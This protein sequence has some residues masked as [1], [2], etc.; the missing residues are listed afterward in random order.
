MIT[1]LALRPC[2]LVLR[3]RCTGKFTA[4]VSIPP[5]RT[6]AANKYYYKAMIGAFLSI[7]RSALDT[8]TKQYQKRV[9]QRS[10]PPGTAHV[11]EDRDVRNLLPSLVHLKDCSTEVYGLATVGVDSLSRIRKKHTSK[12]TPPVPASCVDFLCPVGTEETERSAR[13]PHDA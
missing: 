6:R 5:C 8:R 11:S 13:C 2:S 1:T 4:A 12:P 3:L 10:Y 7:S 9:V